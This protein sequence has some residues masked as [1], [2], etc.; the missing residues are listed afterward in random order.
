MAEFGKELAQVLKRPYWFPTPAFGLK[1]LLGEMSTLVL[2]GQRAIPRKLL[3]SG[4]VYRY[5][6]LHP[7]L[8]NLFG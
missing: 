1:L 5:P 7:A 8:E 2:D 4:Y 3:E 6:Q